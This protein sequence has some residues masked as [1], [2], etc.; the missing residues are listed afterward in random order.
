MVDDTPS[1]ADLCTRADAAIATSRRLKA[2]SASLA[3]CRA[4]LR[5]EGLREAEPAVPR[6]YRTAPAATRLRSSSTNAVVTAFRIETSLN[7]A[8]RSV[9]EAEQRQAR[10]I[11]L[12]PELSGEAQ[13]LA[14]QTLVEIERT[15]VLAR[16][17]LSLLRSLEPD[18]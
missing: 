11:G 13:V 12:M 4:R 15:L 1:F 3:G 6:L 8:I 17:H 9:A 5:G 16:A 14:W 2:E 18:A 7:S 10:Q